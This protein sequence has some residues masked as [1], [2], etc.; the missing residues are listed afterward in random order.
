MMKV[1]HRISLLIVSLMCTGS[2]KALPGDIPKFIPSDNVQKFNSVLPIG[3]EPTA[4]L[5]AQDWNIQFRTYYDYNGPYNGSLVV[6][7]KV[8]DDGSGWSQYEHQDITERHVTIYDLNSQGR[9][10]SQHDSYLD[11]EDFKSVRLRRTDFAY[12][13]QGKVVQEHV[14]DADKQYRYTKLYYY[15][16]DGRLFESVNPMQRVTKYSYEDNATKIE[17][18]GSKTVAKRV[19]DESGHVLE[20]HFITGNKVKVYEYSYDDNGNLLNVLVPGAGE[21][22]LSYDSF[23]RQIS[24]IFS[25]SSSLEFDYDD[26]GRCI[27]EV[28]RDSNGNAISEFFREYKGFRVAKETNINGEVF[29]FTYDGAGRPTSRIGK[30]VVTYFFYDSLGRLFKEEN[31]DGT[32]VEY[33]LDLLDRVTEMK[34]IAVDGSVTSYETFDYPIKPERVF[35]DWVYIESTSEENENSDELLTVP[36]DLLWMQEEIQEQVNTYRM[37]KGLPPL[38][39]DPFLTALCQEHCIAMASGQVQPGHDGI[40]ERAQKVRDYYGAT[41]NFGENVAMNMG[42][43]DPPSTA[44]GGWINSPGHEKQ[45]V[46]SFE[47]TGI[48]VAQTGNAYYFTQIFATPKQ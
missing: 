34:T 21:I 7:Q 1:V 33:T 28:K 38:V 13:Y 44:V 16:K 20:E 23:N 43:F 5:L 29:E 46:G 27:H 40:V 22:T 19:F 15:D 14:S 3:R 35:D 25:D 11:L 30:A 32:S 10:V 45:M 9:V 12:D 47:Y 17:P 31:C 2:L 18:L 6:S 42:Y 4:E 36:D 26:F 24:R 37:S 48:G 41:Q 39:L 8:V